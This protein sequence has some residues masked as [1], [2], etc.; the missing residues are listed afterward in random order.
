MTLRHVLYLHKSSRTR[1]LDSESPK[2]SEI[3]DISMKK[4]TIFMDFHGFRCQNLLHS[5]RHAYVGPIYST[6]NCAQSWWHD[7]VLSVF[8]TQSKWNVF[9]IC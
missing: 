3:H 7:S 9:R 4:T 1:F 2:T 8:A 6:A 5:S